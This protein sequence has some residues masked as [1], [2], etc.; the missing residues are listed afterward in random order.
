MPFF[1]FLVEQSRGVLSRKDVEGKVAFVE[2]VIPYLAAVADP[3]ER[4]EYAKEVAGRAGLDLAL[5]LGKL[6]KAA[7]GDRGPQEP[8][9]ACRFSIPVSDQ[10]LVKGLMDPALRPRALSLLKGIP[11][12]ALAERASAPLL[13]SL[14]EAGQ[15]QGPEQMALLA[16]I[17]NTCHE[18]ISEQNLDSAVAQI[19]E[20]HLRGLERNLQQQ[21]R[22]ASQKG[23]FGLVQILNR[24]KMAVLD[25]IQALAGP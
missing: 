8:Q 2:D 22:D 17:Q 24:E 18:A 1:A 20:D 21:I 19:V 5:V 25:Q 9:A 23:D 11:P 13:M 16:Y 6:A 7:S 14:S 3:I 10:I 15:P 4:Q 12:E